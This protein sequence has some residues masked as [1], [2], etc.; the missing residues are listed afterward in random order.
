[1]K[2]LIDAHL[3]PLLLPPAL[4]YWNVSLFSWHTKLPTPLL[5]GA[6]T[7]AIYISRAADLLY[8]TSIITA[9]WNWGKC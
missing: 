8:L 5:M 3:T 7:L 2:I 4:Q 6:T 9:S 1:M